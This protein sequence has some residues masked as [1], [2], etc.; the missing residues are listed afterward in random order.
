[1]LRQTKNTCISNIW[2][3]IIHEKKFATKMSTKA[4]M[5]Q[6][7]AT[8]AGNNKIIYCWNM[9]TP[10]EKKNKSWFFIKKKDHTSYLLQYPSESDFAPY[11][12]V[13]NSKW[14]KK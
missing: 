8:S 9:L 3:F 13:V 10:F 12:S 1:M 5:R 6:S 14:R 11:H 2:P 7:F 4:I